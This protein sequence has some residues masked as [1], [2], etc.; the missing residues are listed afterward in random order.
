MPN[1]IDT[2]RVRDPNGT[3]ANGGGAA[4]VVRSE[5]QRQ[6]LMLEDSAAEL[7]RQVGV[8]RQRMADWRSGI[9]APSFEARA[10]MQSVLGI[11]PIS[12]TYVPGGTPPPTA[13]TAPAVKPIQHGPAPST[14]EDCMALLAVLRAERNVD[15]LKPSDRVRLSDATARILSL[16][17]RL[18]QAQ[19]LSEDRYVY[20]HPAWKRL[21]R[22]ILEA[23]EAHPAAALAVRQALTKLGAEKEPK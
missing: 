6:L 19:E 12:W 21:K 23:L 7:A 18:E 20:E 10:K 5:G 13:A 9:C 4:V 22:A 8:K 14:L 3:A 17:A 1:V 11:D 15:G 16:R 2:E